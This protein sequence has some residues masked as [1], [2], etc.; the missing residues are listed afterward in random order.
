MSSSYLVTVK[1]AYT[2]T[3]LVDAPTKEKA[4]EYGQDD[5]HRLIANREEDCLENY[6]ESLR[7]TKAIVPNKN[8][9]C[10]DA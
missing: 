6:Y 9:P 5:I 2:A 3:V 10:F 4:I 7:R 1:V 8:H